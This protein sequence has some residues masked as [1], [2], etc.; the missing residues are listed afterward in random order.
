MNEEG[1]MTGKGG[2]VEKI[3]EGAKG[4]QTNSGRKNRRGAKGKKG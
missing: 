4:K 2:D 3:R 1:K